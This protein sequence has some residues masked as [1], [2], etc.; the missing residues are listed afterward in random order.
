MIGILI[1]AYFLF[2]GY[3][4]SCRLFRGKDVYF[5][6]WMGGIFGNVLLMAGVAIPSF[7]FGFTYVSHI[8]LIVLSAVP[9]A[10]FIKKDG[11]ADFKRA[12]G[13]HNAAIPE[14]RVQKKGKG[15][16]AESAA[17]PAAVPYMDWK[18]FL[19]LIL[20]ISLII[21]IIL[22]NHILMPNASGGV[23]TGESTYGDL[24]LHLSFVTSIAEQRQFPPDYSIMPGN[25]IG[26]PFFV[27]MLSSSLFL[28]GT[29]VRWAVLIPSYIIS[30]LLVG[31]FYIVAFTLTKRKAAAVLATIL[32]FFNGGLGFAYFFEGA[33]ADHSVFTQIFT[34]YYHTPT[35]ARASDF[36]HNICWANTICDMIIPQRTTM[37]G[38][39]MIQPLIWLLVNAVKTKQRRLYIMLGVLSGCMLMIH[40]HSFMAFG[41]ICAVM[42]FAY[43]FE[44]KT[45]E[46]KKKFFINWVIF[47]GITA[48]MTVPQLA[49]WTLRQV[50]NDSFITWHFNWENSVD[51]YLW[52]Y[53]KNWGITALFAVPAVLCASKD[54]KKLLAGC[55]LVFIAAEL[56][57]FQPLAYDN[58]K[59]FF[60]A[61]MI[62]IMIIADWLLKM[63][64]ALKNVRGRAYLAVIVVAA[65][66]LSGALTIC[67]E[68]YSGV[69]KDGNGRWQIYSADDLDMAEYIK[70]NLPS[71]AKI[72]TG[73]QLHNP[74]YVLS[75]RDIYLGPGNFV[76]T[77]G[78][79]A[80]YSIMEGEMKKAY[81]GSYDNLISFCKENDIDYVYV[82]P[83][84]KNELNPNMSSIGRLEKVYS[85]GAEALYK[86]N[87]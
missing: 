31:G 20:P 24:Q 45:A 64:D 21:W 78:M 72:L 79:G 70:D 48:V 38:W 73:T 61:Y 26:Y 66:T 5:R 43:L 36:N 58:N 53:L 49:V 82:G 57:L 9:A 11:F 62:L 54:N 25:I 18:I 30:M 87:E 52:F 13:I 63:W 12:L 75:G 34:E 27:D 86:V 74:V 14:Q 28:F 39:C 84:E 6:G 44:E 85:A 41:M 37:A 69:A 40:T 47:G 35:N 16:T 23:T 55:A 59:V 81:S 2:I 32:F 3:I 51:P 15:K 60:I 17:A 4:Y 46:D 22:T 65:G 67:R 68:Y 7:I 33:K 10:Y 50:S 29:P 42:F 71:D 76:S 80:K 83:S 8:V 56:V 19:Y 1:Y 77:H